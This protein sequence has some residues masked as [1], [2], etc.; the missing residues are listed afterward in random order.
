MKKA[1][2]LV[3]IGLDCALPHLVQK[4]IDEGYLPNFKR[5]Y[6][7]GTFCDNT[8]VPYPTITPPNWASIATGATPAT[9]QVTDYWHQIPGMDPTPD[10]TRCSFGSEHLKSETLWESAAKAGKKSIVLNWP[11]A[12]PGKTPNA[13]VIGGHGL[14]VSQ[15][16]NNKP[17]LGRKIGLCGDQLITTYTLPDATMGELDDASGWTNVDVMGKEPLEMAAKM[18]FVQAEVPMAPKTWYVLVRALGTKGYDTVTLSPTKDF[19]DAFFTLKV[20]EWSA[21]VDRTFEMA[22]GSKRDGFFRA[23]LVELDPDGESI[24]LYL[25]TINEIDGFTNPPELA[26]KLYSKEGVRGL[27]SG[28][29]AYLNNWVDGDTW[30]EINDQYTI[31]LED[32]IKYLFANQEWDL[33]FMHSHPT[34]WVYHALMTDLGP[35]TCSDPEK[36]A[37]AWVLHR[38]IYETQDHLIGTLMDLAGED[39][40]YITISDHGAT[41]DG[42]MINPVDILADAGLLV[43]DERAANGWGEKAQNPMFAKY[44]K[45]HGNVPNVEKS[46]ALPSRACFIYINLKGR[47]PHGIVD[48]KDYRKVQYEIID[49]LMNYVHPATGQRPFALAVTK[50][51][52]RLLGQGGEQCGDVV[53]AIRPEYGGQHGQI[54]PTDSYGVGSLK[55]LMSFTGPGV[56]KN[57]HMQRFCNIIDMVPTICHL[58]DLPVPDGCEGAVLYQLLDE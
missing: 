11:G 46:K 16:Q 7:A 57:Y 27:S 5:L 18:E 41:P 29:N 2:K 49:A 38:R 21:R 3:V 17:G 26:A 30:V 19:S 14:M 55:A 39:A 48:P 47:D 54:L 15:Y 28:F 56:K 43:K 42:P 51:E 9:H 31:W 4:H 52:A 53:Y 23:K 8:L 13:T 35:E 44:A 22:D 50:D 33:F 25:T 12:W 6:D 36:R 34:D 45:N 58:M 1:K 24:R 20:G 40:L 10:N 32:A 37:R